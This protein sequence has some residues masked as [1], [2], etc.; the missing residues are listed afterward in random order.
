L[1]EHRTDWGESMRLDMATRRQVTKSVR[2]RYIEASR[3][4]KG[5]ILD[6]FVQ[7]TGYNRSYAA[8][9]LR[10]GVHTKCLAP[11]SPSARRLGRGRKRVYGDAV[12]A[13]LTRI[14]ET[15]GFPCG[16][17]LAASLPRVVDALERHGE[18]RCRPK[19]REQLRGI[20]AATIDRLLA[21]ERARHQLKG[22]SGTKPGSLLKSQIPIHIST[23]WSDARPGFVEID[24]V[25]HCGGDS[26]GDHCQTLT[27]TDVAT[28]WT[29]TRAVRNKAQKWVF[30]GIQALRNQL[31]VSLLGIDSDNGSEFINH[32]LLR[33]CRQEA[34]TFTRA[35]PYRKNDN[36]YVEQ[37]NRTTVR[38]VVGYYRYDTPGELGA[39]NRLYAAQRLLHNYFLAQRKLVEKQRHGSQV[40]RVYDAGATPYA[41]MLSSGVAEQVAHSLTKQYA[42]LN[43]AQLRRDIQTATDQLLRLVAVK[44]SEENPGYEYMSL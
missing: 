19:I 36:C 24:L 41:R 23:D 13:P 20:S 30:A 44:G 5:R 43:P 8:R 18:L 3:K 11:R 12:L 31:P 42:R 29:E 39:L 6:E 34:I 10:N 17:L 26:S 15:L 25:A 16:K 40:T 35:R 32:H 37:K 9:A 22:R 27:M 38:Q 28:G 4:E 14:W 2:D 33:Y 21:P 1:A 7:T